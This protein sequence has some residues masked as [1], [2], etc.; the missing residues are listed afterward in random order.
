MY[1]AIPLPS[2][3]GSAYNNSCSIIYDNAANGFYYSTISYPN[4][5]YTINITSATSGNVKGN[6]NAKLY[7]NST[8]FIN[9]SNGNF[10][11]Y[12]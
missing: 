9:I 7:R 1:L 2:P 12:Y 10:D 4:S 11:V 3:Q 8:N 5:T 6:F